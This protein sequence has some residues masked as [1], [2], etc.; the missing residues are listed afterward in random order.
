MPSEPIPDP[1]DPAKEAGE[2]ADLFHALSQSLDEYRLSDDLPPD[3]PPAELK[4]LKRQAQEM[5]DLSHRFTAEAIGATLQAIQTD[6]AQ[7]KAVTKEAKAQLGHLKTVSKVISI[8][9]AGLSVGTAVVTGNPLAIAKA[10]EGFGQT[11][12]A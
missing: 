12:M 3:T 8:A 11:V 7:I 9:T 1:I 10:L 4:L 2:L 5:E 6:L